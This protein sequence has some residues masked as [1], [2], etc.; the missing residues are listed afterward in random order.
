MGD[1]KEL[2]RAIEAMVFEYYT[3]CHKP[4]GLAVLSR[5][6]NRKCAKAGT[7]LQTCISVLVGH[8][9]LHSFMIDT[10]AT[11]LMPKALWDKL[12]EAT[13]F[14]L[15]RDLEVDPRLNYKKSKDEEPKPIVVSTAPIKVGSSWLAQRDSVYAQMGK[16]AP[17]LEPVPHDEPV[18]DRDRMNE[19]SEEPGNAGMAGEWAE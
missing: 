5:A 9:A 13:R 19:P 3:Q 11:H 4:I 10:G 1:D 15:K 12:P 17:P 2:L 16:V 8:G 7:R 14:Y 18:S 6:F